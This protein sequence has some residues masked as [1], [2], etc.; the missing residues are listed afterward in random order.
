MKAPKELINGI[1]IF[2]GIGLYFLIVNAL[3]HANHAFL[4]VFNILFIFYGVNRTIQMNLLEGETNFVNNAISAMITS[5]LGVFLSVIGLM[6]YS[7]ANGGETYIHS[8]SESFLFGGKP[9]IPTYC[10]G[11]F[12]EGFASSVIVT[13]MLM[14]Y[15]NSRFVAD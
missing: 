9:S 12:F 13:L 14:T 2:L 3:G 15:W 6:F 10:I 1:L 5:V 4:R 11:L 7:Y 8:L